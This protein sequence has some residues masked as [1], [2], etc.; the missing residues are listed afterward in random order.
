MPR[1]L[2][3]RRHVND[4]NEAGIFH[5]GFIVSNILKLSNA[6]QAVFLAILR[7]G[8]VLEV[9]IPFD[10]GYPNLEGRQFRNVDQST[11]LD[12][13]LSDVRPAPKDAILIDAGNEPR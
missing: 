4:V 1:V 8:N 13:A 2:V 5:I 3:A 6:H 12:L 9:V 10:V 11:K 7:A